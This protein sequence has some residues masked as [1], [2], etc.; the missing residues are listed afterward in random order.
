MATLVAKY[1]K[2]RSQP[3]QVIKLP[4]SEQ[5]NRGRIKWN[6]MMNIEVLLYNEKQHKMKEAVESLDGLWI[7]LKG[8]AD[9]G[10]NS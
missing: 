3:C 7:M 1:R 9:K 10:I 6:D 2:K 5:L 4:G 8:A